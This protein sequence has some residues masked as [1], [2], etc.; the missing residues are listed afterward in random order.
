M[1]AEKE[2]QKIEKS[3]K[4]EENRMIQEKKIKKSKVKVNLEKS[5]DFAPS[6]TKQKKVD[7]SNHKS[8]KVNKTRPKKRPP[9]KRKRFIIVR[10]A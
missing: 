6:T 10:D 8:E 3:K 7:Q 4:R 1:K 9:L 5:F 2:Q